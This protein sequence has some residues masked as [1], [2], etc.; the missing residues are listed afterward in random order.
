MDIVKGLG[1]DHEAEVLGVGLG[2]CYV[3]GLELSR[4]GIRKTGHLLLTF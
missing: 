1:L 4:P 2:F 3:L